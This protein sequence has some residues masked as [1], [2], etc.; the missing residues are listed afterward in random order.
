MAHLVLEVLSS[1]EKVKARDPRT[2]LNVYK[3]APG[4]VPTQMKKYLEGFYESLWNNFNNSVRNTVGYKVQTGIEEFMNFSQIPEQRDILMEI[5]NKSL[6]LPNQPS[7][8]PSPIN[9]AQIEANS[10]I[11]N[12]GVI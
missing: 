3:D 1:S 4:H 2:L 10:T 9:H 5:L 11:Q 8:N 7:P 6:N 12:S